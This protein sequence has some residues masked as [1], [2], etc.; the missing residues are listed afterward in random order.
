MK[1]M[2]RGK[3][4]FFC[5]VL[6]MAFTSVSAQEMKLT[7]H[8]AIEIALAENPT[9]KVADKEIA[10]KKIA[11]TEA[12]QALLPEAN[13]TATIQHTLLAAEMNLGGNKFKMGRDNTNTAALAG[14]LSIPLF[15]PAVYQ[16][17]RLTKEDIALAQ[18]KARGSRLDLINQVTKAFYQMLLA[19]DSYKVM[20]ASY[21]T[22]KENYDVVKAKF[23]VG[24]VSEYDKISA[25]VQMRSMSSSLVS[26]ET[27]LTLAELQL[28]VLMG[29]DPT[30]KV[31]IDDQLENYESDL[32]LPSLDTTEGEIESNSSLRQ[33]D[34]NRS[35][36]ERALKIQRTNFMPT[37]AFVLTGQYQS[38][39]NSNWSVWDYSWSPSA[40]FTISVNIPLFRASNWT[41]LKTTKLQLLQL[42]DNRLNTQ[43]QLTMAVESYK[44]NMAASIAQTESNKEAVRQ[45]DK[46]VSIAAKRYEVGRG[47]ILEL[48]QSEV[49]LTSAQLTYNQSIYDYLIAKANLNYTL[50]RED[51]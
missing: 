46:A 35:M 23:D 10:L 51:Y 33:I 38:L 30:V 11:D 19:Q 7:L 16:N 25:E 8:Q 41:K 3:K 4:L 20:Q 2:K 40:S 13:A 36:M 43:R 32:R 18:E 44:Q 27:G 26:T 29:I 14:T 15:A 48:N 47:T 37:V 9:I 39:Y 1:E 21:N 45:A 5:G 34:M 22:S 28:K 50:G 6:L 31:S 17:M 24:K 49:A 12:W 42:D